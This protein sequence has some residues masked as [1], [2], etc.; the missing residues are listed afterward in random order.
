MKELIRTLAVVILTIAPTSLMAQDWSYGIGTGLGAINVDGDSGF[1][2]LL[3]GPIEFDA[4]MDSDEITEVLKSAFAIGGYAKK[5]K[6]TISYAV[7]FLE[8]DD[9]VSVELSPGT[10]DLDINFKTFFASVTVS[11]QIAQSGKHS[12]GIL[13]GVRFSKQEYEVDFEIGT[14]P[15]F[16][17]GVDD[18]WTDFVFGFT[19]AYQISNSLVWN[20]IL[21]IGEG[22]TEGTT[23]IDTGINWQFSDSFSARFFAS[24]LDVDYQN[25]D[26][27]DSDFYF[28]DAKETQVGVSLMYNF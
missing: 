15:I 21:D 13:G 27:G 9:G 28:Y 19:H 20:S 7:S 12:F 8:L 22:D 26:P 5:D 3:L 18:N 6:L 10:G 2:T 4:S 16:S 24:I 17:R 11:Y 14:T 23:H 1:H 25:G